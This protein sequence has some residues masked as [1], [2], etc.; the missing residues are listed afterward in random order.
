V[1]FESFMQ[2]Q[3]I[4]SNIKEAREELEKIEVSIHDPEYDEIDFKLALQHVYHHLNY[5]WN[6]RHESDQALILQS[7]HSFL[8]WS[9]Y[10]K[11]DIED[12]DD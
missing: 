7:E 12:Y 3:Y 1:S 8:T 10:P 6:I 5:A 9:K 4:V 2:K 11:N